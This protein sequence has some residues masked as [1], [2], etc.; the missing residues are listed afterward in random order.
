MFIRKNFNIDNAYLSFYD[1]S[2]LY[3]SLPFNSFCKW[4]QFS[5]NF[6]QKIYNQF[7]NLKKGKIYL[8]NIADIDNI[9]ENIEL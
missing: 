5:Q 9:K 3:K 4:I 8:S 6:E 1:M 7:N 2:M